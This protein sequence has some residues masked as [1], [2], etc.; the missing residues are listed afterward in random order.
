MPATLLPS[1][2]SK[3]APKDAIPYSSEA[4]RQDLGRLRTA[5][6][7]CQATRDRPDI[8]FWTVASWN[9][10]CEKSRSSF[11]PTMDRISVEAIAYRSQCCQNL[12]WTCGQF[13][14]AR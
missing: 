3:S 6:A 10:C 4:I 1:F 8:T 11:Y 5:W 13:D 2:L 12:G 9:G 7:D 14:T